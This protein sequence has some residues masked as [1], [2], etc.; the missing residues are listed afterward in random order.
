MGAAAVVGAA[1]GTGLD[2]AGAQLGRRVGG[3]LARGLE[4]LVERLT[5]ADVAVDVAAGDVVAHDAARAL[6][7]R[8]DRLVERAGDVHAE[9]VAHGERVERGLDLAV[10][11]PARA[12]VHGLALVVAD[13]RPAARGVDAVDAPGHGDAVEREVVE[14]PLE[15]GRLVAR[16]GGALVS[17]VALE[18]D[19]QGPGRGPR[20][21]VARGGRQL[22]DR[23]PQLGHRFALGLRGEPRRTGAKLEPAQRAL[24]DGVGERAAAHGLRIRVH[25][26]RAQ[27]VLDQPAHGAAGEG[28]QPAR[29][30]VIARGEQRVDG[31]RLRRLQRRGGVVLLAR[32]VGAPQLVRR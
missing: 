3:D 9:V 23:G 21:R 7:G 6:V 29:G 14:A 15:L 1:V 22:A 13:D 30:L 8:A 2:A 31:G 27:Q 4:A 5:V 10:L 11:R 19:L 26:A 24:E 25:R 12:G 32:G 16:A 28:L 17:D 20:R 18:V